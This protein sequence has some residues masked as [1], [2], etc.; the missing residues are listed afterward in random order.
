MKTLRCN[1]CKHELVPNPEDGDESQIQVNHVGVCGWCGV[2]SII[3]ENMTVEPLTMGELCMLSVIDAHAYE[4]AVN[5]SRT[6]TLR[7]IL[8]N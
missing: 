3:R 1:F 7:N 5:Y 6:I 2:I 4:Y 8:N